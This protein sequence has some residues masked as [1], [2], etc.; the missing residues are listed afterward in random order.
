MTTIAATPISWLERHLGRSKEIRGIH[1]EERLVVEATEAI[2]HAMETRGVNRAA[3][4][5]LL[6]TS[7]ANIS[8][9]LSGTRNMTLRTL[10]KIAFELDYRVQLDLAEL[11]AVGYRQLE[12]DQPSIHFSTIITVSEAIQADLMG[13]STNAPPLLGTAEHSIAALAA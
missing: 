1:E 11:E 10:G 8:Q 6:G 7:K 13:S 4:A 5:D 12:V 9:M 3:L 2:E